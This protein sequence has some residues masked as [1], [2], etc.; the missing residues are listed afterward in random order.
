MEISDN[1]SE[2]VFSTIVSVLDSIEAND[3]ARAVT[4]DDEEVY[5]YNNSL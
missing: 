4:V 2:T 5:S 3:D 1:I